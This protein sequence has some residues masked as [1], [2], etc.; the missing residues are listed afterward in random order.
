MAN[1]KQ[2]QT[3]RLKM[4]E[5]AQQQLALHFP[6]VP[7]TLLWRRKSND[8]FTNRVTDAECGRWSASL[9]VI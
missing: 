7:E 2:S 6:D 4:S 5:R 9:G 3:R 1:S 8:G